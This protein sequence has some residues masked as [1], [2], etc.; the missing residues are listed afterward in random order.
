[1][2]NKQKIKLFISIPI[3]ALIISISGWIIT[4]LYLTRLSIGSNILIQA[5]IT[6]PNVKLAETTPMFELLTKYNLTFYVLLILS[7]LAL[8]IGF[9]VS[10]VLSNGSSKN[11][12]KD[13]GL[14]PSTTLTRNDQ[15][16][17]NNLSWGAFFCPLIWAL[18]NKLYIWAIASLVPFLNL[19]VWLKLFF[20]GRQIAWENNKQIDFSAFKTRQKTIVWLNILFYILAICAF[21]KFCQYYPPFVGV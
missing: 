6:A 10:L 16:Y 15:I 8:V 9:I 7:L 11:K 18:G 17:L 3:V 21:Y 12:K 2:T 13:T 1:M 20:D 5:G 14:Q 4:K 19:Y